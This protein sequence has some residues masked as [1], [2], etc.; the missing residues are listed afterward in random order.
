MMKAFPGSFPA[1]VFDHLPLE[2]YAESYALALAFIE[3]EADAVRRA[4]KG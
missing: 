3:A 4:Q 1:N 2:R